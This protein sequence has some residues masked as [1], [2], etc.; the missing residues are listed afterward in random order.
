ME[1]VPAVAAACQDP[2][3]PRFT[4]IPSPY[5]EEDARRFLGEAVREEAVGVQLAIVD[6]AS[7]ELLGA[8]GLMPAHEEVVGEVG[9]WV[10]AAARGRGVATRA[11][12]LLAR[13][14]FEELGMVR[15]QL[16]IEPDNGGSLRAAEKAGFTREG[17]LRSWA[18]IKGTRRDLYLYSLLPEE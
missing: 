11:I 18:D 8:I 17:L 10:V 15:L 9:Y 16:T 1:D 3:I 13:C 14:A 5:G 7:D 2:E 4:R 12:R 6:P